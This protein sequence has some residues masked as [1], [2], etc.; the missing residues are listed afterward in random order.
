MAFESPFDHLTCSTSGLSKEQRRQLG[1]KTFDR[2]FR[3]SSEAAQGEWVK[4]GQ[5]TALRK[6]LFGAIGYPYIPY[7]FP[8]KWGAKELLRVSQ[9]KDR[10][11][12]LQ[13]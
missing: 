13:E 1:V 6:E 7:I 12:H 3:E 4:N 2:L 10:L 11:L 5:M 8:I 9:S